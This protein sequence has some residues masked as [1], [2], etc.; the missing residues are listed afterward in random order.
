M[1]VSGAQGVLGG[2]AV[3]GAVELSRHP[4]QH[5][6]LAVVLGAAIKEPA[7]H[8]RPGEEGLREDFVLQGDGGA[9]RWA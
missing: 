1:S 8:P 7:P 5:Q 6:L 2:A 9:V 3:H 4:L